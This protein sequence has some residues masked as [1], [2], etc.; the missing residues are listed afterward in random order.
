M[1]I[2]KKIVHITSS[3]KIGG[4]EQILTTL[5]TH[6]ELREFEHCVLYVHDGPHK[7]MLQQNNIKIYPIGGLFYLLDPFIFFRSVRVIKRIKP[8]VIHTMLWAGSIVGRLAGWW[9]NVPV[10]C[11]YHNNVD[12]YGWLR[13]FIDK[14]TMRFANKIVGVS[15]GVIDSLKVRDDCT[16]KNALVIHNGI[17]V[18]KVIQKIKEQ[19]KIRVNFGLKKHHFIFGT[20]GRF[21]SVKRLDW[22]LDAFAQLYKK[23]NN[24]RLILVGIGLQENYL[25][26]YAQELKIAQLVRFVVGQSSYGYYPLFDCFVMSSAKEGVSIALLE[27]MSYGLPCVVTCSEKHAVIK[28]NI[29]GLVVAANNKIT[30]IKTMDSLCKNNLLISRLGWGARASVNVAW[31]E[32][33][34]IHQYKKLFLELCC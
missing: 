8:D 15:Q 21:E 33:N 10:V 29:N 6:K 30:F 34:M 12:Q 27:A 7:K 26:L 17:D 18:G 28:H 5:V 25:K 4:A 23:N 31:S 14:L 32:Q 19:Q 1:Y 20:V 2:K 13:N 9:C 22:L 16:Y 11:V 3:L 24:V